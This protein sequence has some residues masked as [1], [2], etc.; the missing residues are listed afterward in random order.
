MEW[1]SDI[2]A[3]FSEFGTGALIT[4]FSLIALAA[5]LMI[6]TGRKI[7]FPPGA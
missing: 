5:V 2:F 6:I 4:V 1:F 3:R 7:P